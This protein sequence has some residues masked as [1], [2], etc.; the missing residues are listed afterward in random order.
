MKTLRIAALSSVCLYAQQA[1][2]PAIPKFDVVSIKRCK[3]GGPRGAT[4]SPGRLSTGCAILADIDYV[5]LI[6]VSYNRYAG[7]RMN[8]FRVIPIEG[9][10]DWI[11]SETFEIDARSDGEP[12]IQMMQ[13][14]MMQAILE[15][16]FK[17]RIHRETRQGPVYEIILSK[18]SPKL[19]PFQAGHCIP[20]E[21]GRAAPVLAAGQRYC[22]NMVN[23]RG[24]VDMEGGTVSALAGLLGMALDRPVLDK[25]G[26][27]DP[28]EIHLA[29][30]PDDPAATG[31]AVAN[32]GAPPAPKASDVPG[33]FEAIQE[34]LG[35]KLVPAKGPVDLLVI[36]HIEKPSEN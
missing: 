15:D 35:L 36:D 32:P 22:R 29:F 12:S 19:K 7:G 26:L 23:P 28:F 18:V 20:V 11:H 27:A 16:R 1:P 4:S 21:A 6:Q 34:Q 2:P 17:L 25:T 13:G 14:P 10:P 24:A 8:S 33:I 5:G 30:A 31:P 3:P 9:G